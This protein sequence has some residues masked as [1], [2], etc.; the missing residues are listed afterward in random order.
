MNADA[1]REKL[2]GVASAGIAV[3][4]AA[5][6]ERLKNGRFFAGAMVAGVLLFIFS[7]QQLHFDYARLGSGTLELLP[8]AVKMWPPNAAD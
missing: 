6:P 4:K 5:A 1:V 8:M 3:K 7:L 2:S